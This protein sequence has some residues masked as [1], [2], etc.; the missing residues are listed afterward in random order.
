MLKEL[1]LDEPVSVEPGYL[2]GFQCDNCT[3][4][5]VNGTVMDLIGPS[6]DTATGETQATGGNNVLRAL[7]AKPSISS[8]SL[9]PT[10]HGLQE[11][12]V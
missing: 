1:L 10:N 8:I 6:L 11:V 9:T 5:Q 2:I 12:C 3:L 4:G 7:M